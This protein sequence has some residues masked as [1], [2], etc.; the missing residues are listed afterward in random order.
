MKKFKQETFTGVFS[1]PHPAKKNK[2]VG[3]GEDAYL[4]I[5][6]T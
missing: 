2:N 4:N 3:T 6:S 5:E 1:K